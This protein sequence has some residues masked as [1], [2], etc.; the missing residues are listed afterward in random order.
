MKD[1]K[2][3]CTTEWDKTFPKSDKVEHKKITFRNRSGNVTGYGEI[4]GSTVTYRDSAGNRI[5]SSEYS[6]D[7]II[8][9]DAAGNRW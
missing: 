7:N 5:G 9:R 2:L 3:T 6:S 8:F 1:E 4:S